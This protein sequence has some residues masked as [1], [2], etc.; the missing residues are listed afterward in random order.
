MKI[1]GIEVEGTP[2]E[3]AVLLNAMSG[4]VPQTVATPKNPTTNN[5][6]TLSEPPATLVNPEAADNPEV[7]EFVRNLYRYKADKQ[8]AHGK[9]PYIVKILGNSLGEYFTIKNL[10][11]MANAKQDLVS[12]AI[13]RAA[14]AG[15]IIEVNSQSSVLSRNTKIRMTKLGTVEQAKSTRLSLAPS[16]TKA[17][18]LVRPASTNAKTSTP[19]EQAIVR[20]LQSRNSQ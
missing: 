12:S 4:A 8:S 14:D 7:D 2:E 15:C 17:K 9:A 16:V 20:L 19:Q 5:L 6:V 18:E 1:N 10:M 3:I 11:R 13:R